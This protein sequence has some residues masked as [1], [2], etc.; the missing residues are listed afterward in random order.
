MSAI[1]DDLPAQLAE[2]TQRGKDLGV[3]EIRIAVA[4]WAT[5]HS[6]E[7]SAATLHSLLVAVGL[8][9]ADPFVDLTKKGVFQDHSCARCGDGARACPE[10]NPRQCGYLFA[11]ND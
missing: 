11:R 5:K 1:T 6:S 7:L 8:A 9:E 10:G 3:L 2:I 4:H